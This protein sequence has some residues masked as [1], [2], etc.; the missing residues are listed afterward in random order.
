MQKKEGH[1]SPEPV[2]GHSELTPEEK[3]GPR[4]AAIF[5]VAAIAFI[6]GLRFRLGY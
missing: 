5:V 3:I 4:K 2:N 1:A 6:L